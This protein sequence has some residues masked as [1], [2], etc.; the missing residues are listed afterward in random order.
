MSYSG[1]ASSMRD[2]EGAFRKEVTFKSVLGALLF[3]CFLLGL[4][5][6]AN[7]TYSNSLADPPSLINLWVNAL[8]VFFVVHIYDLLVLD[9]LIVVKWHPKFLNLP[10]TSYYRTL[11]PHI[12]GFFK[13]IS[14]GILASLIA[15]LLFHWM[16]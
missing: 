10:N 1:I 15:S 6:F 4:L 9:Y 12:V 2:E 11:R 14:L 5:F 3:I 16:S 8:G 7:I 13:G